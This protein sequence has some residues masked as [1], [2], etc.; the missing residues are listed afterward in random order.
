MGCGFDNEH[1]TQSDVNENDAVINF[2]Q[3][4]STILGLN[5]PLNLPGLTND[6]NVSVLIVRIFA[7][8]VF[9]II[10]FSMQGVQ[11]YIEIRDQD[12]GNT[13]Q[14]IDVFPLAV[15]IESLPLNVPSGNKMFSRAVATITVNVTVLCAQNFQGSNCTQCIPGF[16][17]AMCD[18]NIDDCL[19]EMCSGNGQCVDEVGSYSCNCSAGYNG[20]DCEINI[21][22]C[23]PSPCGENGQCTDGVNSFT[24]NCATGYTGTLCDSDIDECLSNPCGMNSRCQNQEGSFNCSCNPGFTGDLC[25]TDIDDCVGVNCSGN[26][27][28]V[29]GVNTFTCHDQGMLLQLVYQI[30]KY[31]MLCLLQWWSSDAANK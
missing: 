31:Y 5:N 25:Q 29:D 3:N 26:G 9:N 1:V 15:R 7:I 4:I 24:C 10:S 28:C 11:L 21:D 14:L 22:H 16:T 17:G 12:S 18:E 27:V 13:S 23:S 19:G 8:T 2:S 30:N 6:W 20:T